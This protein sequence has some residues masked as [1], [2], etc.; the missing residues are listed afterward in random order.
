MTSFTP[1]N[2]AYGEFWNKETF[3]QEE[4]KRLKQIDTDQNTATLNSVPRSTPNTIKEKPTL[5]P[6][7]WLYKDAWKYYSVVIPLLGYGDD[8][9]TCAGGVVRWN[10]SKD[11]LFGSRNIFLKH[12]LRDQNIFVRCPKPH[13]EFF[14]SFVKYSLKAGNINKIV[15][16][17]PSISYDP[18]RSELCARGGNIG[19]NI[20]LINLSIK[21]DQG[22]L[23]IRQIN[24]EGLYAQLLECSMTPSNLIGLY[25]ELTHLIPPNIEQNNEAIAQTRFYTHT[26]E[27][28]IGYM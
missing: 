11:P 15:A 20:A 25:K 22:I 9:E 26:P 4:P 16:L 13:Y 6:V 12:E 8:V 1:I 24:S 23:D 17:S 28:V 18:I 2:L 10:A 7:F 21:I 19:T 27:G 14:Y 5:P 3:T